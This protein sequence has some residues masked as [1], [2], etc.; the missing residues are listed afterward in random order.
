MK[1]RFFT[2]LFCFTCF[3]LLAQD[4]DLNMKIVAHVPVPEGG[5]GIW[6]FVDKNKIEYAVF[7]SKDAVIIYSLED[8]AKPIERFRLPGVNTIWR[9]VYIYGDYIYGVND[10]Q[11]NG[12][13]IINM[14][15]APLNITGKF[16]KANI[17]A[18]GQTAELNTCHTV[19]VDDKG[20]LYLNGCTPWR[21]TLIF[22]ISKQPEN[23]QYL[24][25]Q[26]KRYC[27]D[28]FGRNDTIWSADVLD[29]VLSI[30]DIRNPAAPKEMAAVTTPFAFTHN[31]WPS[32]DGKFVFT[33]DERDNAYVASYDIQDLANIKLLDKYR[34]KDTEGKGVIPH[35]T[36]YI[37]G[38]LVTSFYTDGVKIT[39]VHRPDNMVEVGSVDTWSGPHGGFNGCWGVS[40]F[41]PS[42]TIV[43]SDIQGGLFV[44]KPT[45]VRACYL[46]G[47]VVDSLTGFP[48]SNATIEILA[49]RKNGKTS[50][51]KGEYKTG[52]AVSGT[53]SVLFN[54]PEYF[55]KTISVDLLNGV[56]TFKDVKLKP[57]N[58]L[59]SPKVIVKDA[60]TLQNIPD[61]RVLFS[62]PNR[63][64]NFITDQTGTVDVQVFQD[65]IPYDL[66][67]G[68]WGYLHKKVIFDSQNPVPEITILMSKGYQD[69][70]LFDQGWKVTSTASSG[71]WTRGEPKGTFQGGVAVAPELDLPNDFGV[72]CYI[73]GNEGSTISD[74]DIDNGGTVLTS[75]VMNLVTYNQPLLSYSTWFANQSGSGIPNDK[76][77]VRL[78][79][80]SQ[81]VVLDEITSPDPKWTTKSKI[82]LKS[83]ITLTDSMVLT[84]DIAD[85][86]PGHVLE[87]A[88]DGFLVTEGR[89]VRAIDLVNDKLN[90]SGYP[91]RFNI[92]TTIELNLMP[93][94][95]NRNLEIF[96]LNGIL[97][98]KIQVPEG[99]QNIF[100]GQELQTGMYS[101]RFVS[102][103]G[104]SNTI[105]ILKF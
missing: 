99:V 33:T 17:T 12:L 26:T 56:V 48:I 92:Q 24:G 21:G 2:F 22:D 91:S 83:M 11:A 57:R 55:P 94:L 31:A 8:P 86:N 102:E 62:N 90:I 4:G 15:N 97:V 3:S 98:S 73:T 43:A 39:D 18:N 78:N 20:R 95:K 54:H 6:H 103:Q 53:Y 100:V 87:G 51:L 34:P 70:F 84:I 65:T 72:E 45:Y 37:N 50:D 85:D 7:G 105:R 69:D 74:D 23:P 47:K 88:F 61:V 19:F 64:K 79:N 1:Y 66:F 82:D 46:E 36:R 52:Y 42:G 27:H 38:Y 40:P 93:G 29:G 101:V 67:A 41:L 25:A 16:W 5:S 49:P 68:K 96:N 59:L 75:P 30:W 14:K 63:D 71:T 60:K 76:M 77:V 35:N 89:P 80:G 58:V 13:I 104:I 28:N 32:D 44:I 81:T 9:E 10:N